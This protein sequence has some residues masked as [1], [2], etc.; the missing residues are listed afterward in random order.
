MQIEVDA[1]EQL[2]EALAFGVD[3]VLLDNMTPQVVA[4]AVRAI[5]THPN[6]A[7]CWIGNLS[8]NREAQNFAFTNKRDL[9][10]ANTNLCLNIPPISLQVWDEEGIVKRGELLADAAVN[11]WSGPR[12]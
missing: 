11:V 7:E 8:V 12:P 4:I 10:I 5:R 3:A 9:L 1:L 6:G 2:A